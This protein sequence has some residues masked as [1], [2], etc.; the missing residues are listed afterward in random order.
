MPPPLAAV[1]TTR[2]FQHGQEIYFRHTRLAC[3]PR[4]VRLMGFPHGSG[5]GS[6]RDDDFDMISLHAAEQHHQHAE[7]PRRHP[8]DFGR[9]S[10]EANTARRRHGIIIVFHCRRLFAFSR[11]SAG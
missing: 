4:A 9:F 10:I 1:A 6:R 8:A 11:A 7:P 2:R 3:A 5:R